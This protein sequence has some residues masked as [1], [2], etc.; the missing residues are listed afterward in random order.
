MSNWWADKLGNQQG[1]ATS[2]P[3]TRP[4]V[5]PYVSP[6]T[7]NVHRMPVQYDE[8]RDAL[9]TK[10]Q[11][12]RAANTCPECMS[13]NYMKMPGSNYQRCYD[14]GYPVMQ[15][16][17]GASIPTDGKPAQP[18]TQVHGVN[19]YNPNNIVGKVE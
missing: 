11:H 5:Q 6:G 8:Q 9:T 12:L 15:S 13:G 19:N 7:Q 18:A 14:C 16:G 3:P 2:T 17:S 10:P 4:P 1:P